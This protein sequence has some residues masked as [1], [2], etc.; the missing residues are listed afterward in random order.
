MEIHHEG[1][2]YLYNIKTGII[3]QYIC[4]KG[5]QKVKFYAHMF[6]S[7][8]LGSLAATIDVAE[9]IASGFLKIKTQSM[10]ILK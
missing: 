3:K 1:H 8:K 7:D 10:S 6:Y 4:I 2:W 5:K 9:K